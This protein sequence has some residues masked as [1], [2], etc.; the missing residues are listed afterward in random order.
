[1]TVSGTTAADPTTA[2]EILSATPLV[3]H[4]LA[5]SDATPASVAFR[6]KDRGIW[7]E[8]TWAAYARTVEQY[9]L[10]LLELGVDVG[11]R[12]CM[13][14]RPTPE[15]LYLDFACQSIGATFFGIYVTTRPADVRFLLEDGQPTVFMAE[16]QEFVDRLLDAEADAEGRLVEHIVVADMNGI[17]QYQDPRLMSAE[18]LAVRGEA[19][20]SP[21]P[22]PGARWSPAVVLTRC[23]GSATPPGPPAVPRGRC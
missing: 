11:D 9:A 1:M 14:G 13:M 17:F 4:F 2:P 10:G 21:R 3:Q 16:D 5:R 19:A 15:W 7:K 22:G 20:G 23:P 18:T 8:V 12:V 6:H